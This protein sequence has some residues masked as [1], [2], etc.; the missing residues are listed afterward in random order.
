MTGELIAGLTIGAFALIALIVVVAAVIAG[1]RD[2]RYRAALAAWAAQ[3]GWAYRAGGGGEWESLLPKGSGRLGVKVQLECTRAGRPLAMAHYRYQTTTTT[4]G[5]NGVP[6]TS[7]A[8]HDLTVAVVWLAARYP[9]VAVE[10]RH[11]AG[12]GLA[13]AKAVGMR[14]ANLTG[15]RDF[16]RRFRIRAGSPAAAALVT[17]PLVSA[18]LAGALPPWQLYGNQLVV[19]W[20]G[21]LD[22]ELLE[23]QADQAVAIAALLGA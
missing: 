9:A 17:P 8:T 15:N 18:H 20:R 14:P 6:T 5:A 11:G 4:A 12:V 3:R 16:D 2:Q 10:Q 19:S 13:V 7:H 22:R 23:R 21:K 1:K